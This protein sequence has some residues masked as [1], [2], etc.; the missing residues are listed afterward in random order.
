MTRITRFGRCP[1]TT[2]SDS[3]RALPSLP[4]H[5]HKRER[6]VA[7]PMPILRN[8]QRIE[9]VSPENR[10]TLLQSKKMLP[11]I[12]QNS[13]GHSQFR[14][15]LLIRCIGSRDLTQVSNRPCAKNQYI[16]SNAAL[17]KDPTCAQSRENSFQSRVSSINLFSRNEDTLSY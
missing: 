16:L 12:T 5:D 2:R 17:L 7:F 15:F 4:I 6:L 9:D 3:A 8:S 1:I 13:I 11:D 14:L 10:T